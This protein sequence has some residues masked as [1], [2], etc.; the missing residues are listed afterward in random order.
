M[1]DM[2]KPEVKLGVILMEGLYFARNRASRALHLPENQFFLQNLPLRMSFDICTVR[3]YQVNKYKKVFRKFLDFWQTEPE[4]SDS[5][6]SALVWVSDSFSGIRKTTVVPSSVEDVM[7]QVHSAS[8]ALV[9]DPGG[10]TMQE[11][12]REIMSFPGYSVS[13]AG[14]VRNDETGHLMS[15]LVNQRG[16]IHVGLTKN[17]TQYKRSLSILVAEAFLIRPSFTFDTPINLDGDRRNNRADNLLWR[18]RNF[19]TRYYRQ[20][21]QTHPCFT[22]K[23]QNVET[24]EIFDTSWQAALTLGVL[25]RDIAFSIVSGAIVPII[26]Q[27]FCLFK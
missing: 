23:V 16:I 11:E 22:R 18:P 20:F 2:G 13:D 27:H 10:G 3:R 7:V 25:D 8:F 6:Q 26:L 14:T 12:W 9:S 5:L 24:E 21:Q 15:H 17:R 19:A 4:L 1:S